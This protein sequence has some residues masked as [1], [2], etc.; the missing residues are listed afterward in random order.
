MA[1]FRIETERLV[2][3]D[4]R[5]ADLEPL[6]ALCTCPQVMATI[7][8]VHDERKSRELLGRLQDRQARDGCTFWAMQRKSDDRMIGFCGVGRGTVPQIERESEIGWRLVYECWG[9][10][11]AREAAQAALDWAWRG[12][13]APMVVAITAQRNTRSR[14]L[15]ERL[16]LARCADEDFDHPNL[17]VGDPLRPHVLYRIARPH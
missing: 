9:Q 14:G 7:G 11:Y 8:P 2:L 1:E 16:G 12:L 15:M 17:A 13:D 6:H 3:R 10:S 4:W 5:D